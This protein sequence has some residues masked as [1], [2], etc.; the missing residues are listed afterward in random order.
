MQRSMS[1]GICLFVAIASAEVLIRAAVGGLSGSAQHVVLPLA[2]AGLALSVLLWLAGL[3]VSKAR[4][5][6]APRHSV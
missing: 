2:I 1:S 5:L 6:R 4:T 3:L